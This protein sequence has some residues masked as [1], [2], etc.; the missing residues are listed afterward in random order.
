MKKGGV[1]YIVIYVVQDVTH[2]EG[3]CKKNKLRLFNGHIVGSQGGER[4][5]VNREE[6]RKESISKRWGA[7]KR[8]L[9]ISRAK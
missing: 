2:Y 8:I 6:Q 4:Y 5:K 9:N 1:C 7:V 3:G